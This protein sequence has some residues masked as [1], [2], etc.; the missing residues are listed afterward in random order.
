M[1]TLLHVL[2]VGHGNS[3]VL[4]D[5]ETVI[6]FDAGPRTTLLE[7]LDR[8]QIQHVDV[9]LISHADKDH[10]EALISLIESRTVTI[11]T[12]RLNPNLVKT[13]AIWSH[14]TELLDLEDR[15]RR[16]DFVPTLTTKDT[17]AFDTKNVQVQIL[18]PSPGVAAAGVGSKRPE[19]TA[20]TSNSISVVARLAVADQAYVILMG[21]IS[22]T[23]FREM[24]KYC[25]DIA[26]PIAIY[27]HHGGHSDRDDPLIL[28]QELCAAVQPTCVI[29]STG[30]GLHGTPLPNVVG[31][32]KRLIPGVRFCCT[33]LSEHCA[34][35]PPSAP[36]KHLGARF[37][38]GLSAN[39]CC[40]GTITIALSGTPDVLQP[41]ASEHAIFVQLNAP[42]ALCKR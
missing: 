34:A 27:P 16:L 17:G 28:A 21:D 33:Q 13:T 31:E 24:L 6:V 42:T 1:A 35:I 39:K 4:I 8:E 22:L 14:L 30:R 38:A 37:S 10:I 40:T 41:V 15:E 7:F 11:G 5:E 3:S 29:F 19:K 20:I 9:V 25:K 23:G 32:L 2:D 36:F 18:A 26:T 12:V